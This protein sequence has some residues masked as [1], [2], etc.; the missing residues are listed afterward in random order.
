MPDGD[1]QRQEEEAERLLVMIGQ[2]TPQ[3]D[4]PRPEKDRRRYRRLRG[5]GRATCWREHREAR[6]SAGSEP[7][8]DPE[9]KSAL[10]TWAG[11]RTCS[12]A[13]ATWPCRSWPPW[14]CCCSWWRWPRACGH[15]RRACGYLGLAAACG[16]LLVVVVSGRFGLPVYQPLPGQWQRGPTRRAGPAWPR[17]PSTMKADKADRAEDLLGEAAE[18]APGGTGGGGTQQGAKAWGWCSASRRR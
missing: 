12:A 1:R 16:L 8:E 6:R 14:W 17:S 10:A 2:S 7:A 9:Y 15:L 11:I 3:N 18:G 4:G 5:E 13:A